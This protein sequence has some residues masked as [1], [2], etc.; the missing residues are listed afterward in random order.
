MEETDFFRL[1]AHLAHLYPTFEQFCLKHGFS[2]AERRSIGRYPRIRILKV[3]DVIVYIDFFMC[4]DADGKR[5]ESFFESIPYDLT[6]G[7]YADCSDPPHGVRYQTDFVIWDRIPFS[8][9]AP[10][11][12][13]DA[14]ESAL[15]QLNGW[16]VARLRMNGTAVMLPKL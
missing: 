10:T 7:A 11:D 5:Y 6:A 4:F 3:T 12:L 8:S 13:A 1:S 16:T 9:I 15:T 2:F 14:M